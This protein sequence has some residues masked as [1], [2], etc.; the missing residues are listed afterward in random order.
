[1]SASLFHL[2]EP[3]VW[4]AAVVA[5]SYTTSTLGRTLEE[6]G[7]VH[8]CWEH[9]WPQVRRRFHA[10][11]P[12]DL[13]L[14]EIDPERLEAPVVEEPGEPGSDELFPHVYGPIDPAA[15]VATTVLHPP[16]G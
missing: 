11:V 8:A 6:E 4:E 7:F 3:A 5:G 12:T 14:L 15:V 13:L 2:A 9:Q 16:H 10:R 1:M